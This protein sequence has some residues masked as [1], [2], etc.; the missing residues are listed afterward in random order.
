MVTAA[1]FLTKPAKATTPT[2][3][4]ADTRKLTVAAT[5]AGDGTLSKWQYQLKVGSNDWGTGWTDISSTSTSLSHTLTGLTDG[6]D[7]RIKV[8]AVNATGDGATSDASTAV[9]PAPKSLAASSVEATAATLTIEGH[10]G[11]WYYKYTAPAGGTCSASAVSTLATDLTGLVSNTSYTYKAYT[12]SGCTDANEIVAASAFLTKPGKATTPSVATNVGNGK[13]TLTASVTGGGTLTGWQYQQKA[14]SASEYGSWQDVSSTS[15]SLTHTV[16]SLT[17]GT[18]Y[19]FK[20]RARNA[21]GNGAA[22]DASTAATPAA[23]TLG[24]SSV[25]AATATL[26]V[27]KWSGAWYYK[28]TAEGGGCQGP[29][30]AGT[31]TKALTDLSPN[32]SY[33]YKAYSASGCAAANLL[34]TASSFLTKPGKP[35]KPSAGVAGT[36]KLLLTASV[37]GGGAI[38][39]WEYQQKEGTSAWDTT[40]TAITSTSASL[41]H[42]VTDLTNG[43]DYKFKV[44]AKNATGT[45]AT[46][47]ESDAVSPAPR[48][49]AGSSVQTTTATLTISGYTGAWYY[50]ANAAPDTSCK[51][52]VASGTTTKALTNLTTNT[53]YTYKAYSDSG[54]SDTNLLVTATAFLTKPGTATRPTV[55]TNVGSGKLKIASSV[56]G[57]GTL[58]K[59]QYKQKEQGEGGGDFG[60]WQDVSSTSTSLSHTV[61]GLT[62]GTGYRFKVRAVNTGGNG[63]ESSASSTATPAAPTLGSSSVQ[64]ATATLTIGKWGGA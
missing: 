15:A 20:V 17:N 64:A 56:T 13:L 2:L 10:S 49:L 3:T 58:E 1:A 55:T 35:T 36:G 25:E 18:S 4:R 59:W 34:A 62:D 8:R 19:Q 9:S 52:P 6:T 60:S 27:G 61:T 29:I 38:T 47:D 5:V 40:W 28:H 23:P 42:T 50:K 53:S 48:S 39:G 24:S 57:S 45:G 16:G 46:S 7:Y 37:T 32:T 54:C 41:S 12:D 21:S 63:A 31:T 33:T 43:T 11:D 44:R 26:T 30:S 22:S 14:S 51:G